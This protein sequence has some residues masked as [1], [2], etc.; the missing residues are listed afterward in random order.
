MKNK[1]ISKNKFIKLNE[2]VSH[3]LFKNKTYFRLYKVFREGFTK[4]GCSPN[5]LVW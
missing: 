1:I 3:N 2:K 4:K 5:F